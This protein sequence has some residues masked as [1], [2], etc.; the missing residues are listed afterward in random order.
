[1]RVGAP[2]GGGGAAGFDPATLRTIIRGRVS[3]SVARPGRG[4]GSVHFMHSTGFR[5]PS[6]SVRD[7]PAIA[8]RV[9]APPPLAVPGR[10]IARQVVWLAAPV[11][12]EQALLY[13]VGFSDTVL[14]GRYLRVEHL[15]AVTVSSYLLWFLGSLMIV[16]SSGATAL[17]ARLFGAGRRAAAV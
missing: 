12:V 13:M 16:V 1:P 14:T 7:E 8:D 4:P 11:L 9:E 5:R 6:V 15:A 10:T 3:S 17:V 2:S